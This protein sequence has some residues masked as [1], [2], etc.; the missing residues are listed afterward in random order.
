VVDGLAL[1]F[2]DRNHCEESYR[3]ERERLQSPPELRSDNHPS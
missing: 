2:R 3:S 1:L